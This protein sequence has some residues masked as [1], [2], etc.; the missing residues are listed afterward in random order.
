VSP[1]RARA[2]VSALRHHA[3]RLLIAAG[4][5]LLLAPFPAVA[6]SSTPYITPDNFDVVHVVAPPPAPGSEDERRDLQTVIEMQRTSSPERMRLAERDATAGLDAFAGVLGLDPG[7]LPGVAAFFR[8]VGRDTQFATAIGKDCWERPRPFVLDD[9]VHPPGKMQQQV[10]SRPGEKNTAP[11]GPGS[12]CPPLLQ[13]P[14]YSYSYPSGH[15]TR[16]ALTAI[17]L[18]QMVPEKSKELFTRGWDFGE[19]RVIGGVHYPSDVEAGR[20]DATAMATLMMV[21]P[22]FQADFAVARLELRKALGLER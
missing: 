7:A 17:L 5:L 2:D 14:E 19:S 10:A 13:T 22:E 20:I 8:K 1:Q 11:H 16:G 4:L 15:S 9:R 18:A 12:P 3:R 21:N 6:L